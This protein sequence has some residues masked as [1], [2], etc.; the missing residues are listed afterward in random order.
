LEIKFAGGCG[1]TVILDK[2]D[3]NQLMATLFAEEL[4]AVLHVRAEDEN[5][6]QT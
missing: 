3:N 1:L 6:R 2:L 5:N 4:G